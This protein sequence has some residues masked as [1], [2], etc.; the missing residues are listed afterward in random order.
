MMK[1]G[2]KRRVK[3]RTNMDKKGQCRELRE[4][5]NI[6]GGTNGK[7]DKENKEKEMRR[8]KTKKTTKRGRTKE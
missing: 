7:E 4:E 2:K 8:R 3:T 1:T 5:E 6:L